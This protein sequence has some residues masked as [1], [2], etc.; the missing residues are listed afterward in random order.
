MLG[1]IGLINT[2][3]QQ[4]KNKQFECSLTS[5]GNLKYIFLYNL[6][7]LNTNDNVAIIMLIY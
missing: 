5:L 2:F 4:K 1:L 7:F 6:R 3:A